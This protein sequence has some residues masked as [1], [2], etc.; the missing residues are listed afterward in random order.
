MNNS[1]NLTLYIIR[2]G[3]FFLS[4][5][6]LELDNGT[7]SDTTGRRSTTTTTTTTDDSDKIVVCSSFCMEWKNTAGRKCIR[8]K[9]H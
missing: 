5:V 3:L 4:C 7:K 9:Q 2:Y 8:A 6:A 1:I